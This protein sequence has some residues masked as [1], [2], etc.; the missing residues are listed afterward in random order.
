MKRAIVLLALGLLL[1]M[2]Q[3]A[4]V[5]FLPRGLFPDLA[6]LLVI[7][8]GVALR[9][10]AG[11]VALA[12][13]IGFVSDLLSGSL[14]GQHTLLLLLA[15][16]TARL[17]SLHMNMRGPFTQMALAAALTVGLAL[18]MVA[19]TAFFNASTAGRV[20]PAGELA[21]H[22]IANALM[23]PLVIGVAARLMSRLGD[24]DGRRVLRIEPRSYST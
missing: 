4:L 9:S 22:M 23:A 17:T 14:L 21:R 2:I 12:A 7:A 20:A 6:L 15:F 11:G 18:G 8:V 3:G 19:I 16:G 10:T 1:P 5:V 13:W 24:D